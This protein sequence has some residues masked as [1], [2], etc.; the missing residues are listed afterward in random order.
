M[1]FLGIDQSPNESSVG[2]ELR[3]KVFNQV[4]ADGSGNLSF[5]EL[6]SCVLSSSEVWSNSL[7]P[8]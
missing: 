7:S 5:D 6:V 2:G 3:F 4:D 1:L 8:G